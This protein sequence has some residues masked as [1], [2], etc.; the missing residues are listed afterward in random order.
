MIV[1]EKRLAAMLARDERGKP[2]HWGVDFADSEIRGG[3]GQPHIGL[4]LWGVR[5]KLRLVGHNRP[6]KT[7]ETEKGFR[8]ELDNPG[9]LAFEHRDEL[10]LPDRSVWRPE[11]GLLKTT[12]TLNR[13]PA[14]GRWEFQLDLPA[15]VRYHYQP[16]LTPE[17]IGEGV[18]GRPAWA[19][20]SYAVDINGLKH[21]HVARPF[22]IDADGNWTWGVVF[23]EA[24]GLVAVEIDDA[25]LATARY[26]VEV[27]P[28][29]GYTSAGVSTY[30]LLADYI[31]VRTA[32]G[33]SG[34]ATAVW[35]YVSA[36]VARPH[37]QGVY[38]CDLTRIADTANE[39][40]PVAAA[41][42]TQTL[43]ASFT[44]VNGAQYLTAGCHDDGNL[45]Y[46]YD[47]VTGAIFGLGTAASTYSSGSLPSPCVALTGQNRTYRISSYI[48]A[49]DPVWPAAANVATGSGLFGVASENTPSYPTTATS[50]A[51]QKATD[52]DFLET[53]KDEIITTDTDILAEFGVT[54]TAIGVGAPPTT[55]TLTVADNGNGT[56][57]MATI[58]GS[59]AGTTNTVYGSDWPGNAWASKGSRTG[60]DTVAMTLAVGP[61]WFYVKSTNA[62]GTA[63]SS[64]VY[65]LVTDATQSVLLRIL[66][67]SRTLLR[68]LSLSGITSAGIDYQKLPWDRSGIKPGVWIY[69][70]KEAVKPATNEQGDVEYP[71]EIVYARVSN[72]NLTD[73]M[74]A[75]TLWRQRIRRAFTPK[76]G[77]RP[78]VESVSEVYHVRVE[79]GEMYWPTGFAAMHDVGT[80]RVI[81]VAR[82]TPGV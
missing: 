42:H 7:V 51:A 74:A 72:Q 70:T 19:V 49:T 24:T 4:N 27:D 21:G 30:S 38:L 36:T 41:W 5:G 54:G 18:V 73:E 81:C 80:L 82:E 62:N 35:S 53:N 75:T 56:G 77:Y 71:I 17:E 57:A 13:R 16:A 64:L 45:S 22:A 61:W 46:Y 8:F 63:A 6:M 43:D 50:Q 15:G 9:T 26:P 44:L 66:Q 33:G 14:R 39:N 31:I 55:P 1:S 79:V 11:Q 59:T 48:A 10:V 40:S 47:T 67:A 60:N 23:I 68:S 76:P 25:W 12:L 37:T 58:S 20:G 2:V 52:A 3:K 34:V 29:V 28:N 78:I 32:G 65:C 69:P